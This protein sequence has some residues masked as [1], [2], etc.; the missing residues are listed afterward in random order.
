MKARNNEKINY[1][2]VIISFKRHKT[3]IYKHKEDVNATIIV[4]NINKLFWNLED[5]KVSFELV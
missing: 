4:N 2:Y 5:K 1:I 3:K